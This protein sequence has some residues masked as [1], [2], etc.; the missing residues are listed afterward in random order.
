MC[1]AL[2]TSLSKLISGPISLSQLPTSSAYV[3]ISNPP[4]ISIYIHLRSVPINMCMSFREDS[5]RHATRK[6]TGLYMSQSCFGL[7]APD[8]S[9]ADTCI[10]QMLEARQTQRLRKRPTCT[11]SGL[12]K[13]N[14][15]ENS[16]EIDLTLGTE[17]H[18]SLPHASDS[19]SCRITDGNHGATIAVSKRVRVRLRDW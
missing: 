18:L 13:P 9:I 3:N 2:F 1:P 15:D 17:G 11:R 4:V 16:R 14:T 7:Q 10:R 8:L 6:C 19:S 5:H 12:E